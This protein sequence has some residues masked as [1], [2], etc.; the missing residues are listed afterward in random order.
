MTGFHPSFSRQ[1]DAL[2]PSERYIASNRFSVREARLGEGLG[3]SDH[4][5][6]HETT[7]QKGRFWQQFSR[8]KCTHLS[9][10][11]PNSTNLHSINL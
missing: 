4:W 9:P 11:S 10:S 2:Q 6:E 7:P 1:S 5:E 3:F 8:N